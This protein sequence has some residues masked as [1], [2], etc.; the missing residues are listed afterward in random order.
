MILYINRCCFLHQ[1]LNHDMANIWTSTSWYGPV[2]PKVHW[3][4]K[5]VLPNFHFDPCALTV[6]SYPR[7]NT[8]VNKT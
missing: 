4:E 6:S 8:N 2:P 7:T 1:R 5:P 3:S